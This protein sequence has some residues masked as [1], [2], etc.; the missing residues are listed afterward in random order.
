MQ[1]TPG[2]TI[3]I[4]DTTYFGRG[5][6]VMVFRCALRKINLYWK[7]LPYETT[8]EYVAGIHYLQQRGWII[9]GLVFDGRRGLLQAFPGIPTQMCQF[10]QVQIVIR[11]ITRRPKLEAGKALKNLILLLTK[12]DKESFCFW[13]ADWHNNWK[14][15][16]QEKV[17]DQEKKRNRYLHRKLRSAYRSLQTNLPY[18]F[19]FYDHPE[20]SIPNTTNILDGYFSIIKEKVSIHRGVTRQRKMK[21]ID[22][23]LSLGQPHTKHH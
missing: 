9:R 19:T 12:T 20:L 5:F 18:L 11:Y 15:F 13:L 16:L 21:I 17:Y 2:E 23:L 3:L 4:I 8:A 10:H 6:G 14:D 7:F 22:A 1:V